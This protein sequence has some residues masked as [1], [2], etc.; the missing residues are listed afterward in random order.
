MFDLGLALGGAVADLG[1]RGD[2]QLGPG[3]GAE[4]LG[5]EILPR[6][7]PQVVVHV[8]RADGLAD[9]HRRR[10]TGTDPRPGAPGSGCTIRA[11]R[12]SLSVTVW[13]LPLL[14][15]NSK[16][17]LDPET[18][19]CRSCS[20]VRPNERLARAYSSLPM[21]IPVQ[22]SRRTTVAST[23]SRGRPWLAQVALHPL[24]RMRGSD[25]AE[26]QHPAELGLVPHLPPLRMVAVLFPAARV[27]AGGLDVAVGRG[28]DP[29]VGVRRWNGER[30]G[31][32]PAR[33]RP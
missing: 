28:T 15:R 21:R 27:A 11:S 6:D 7:L 1:Q 14:P 10:G 2:G 31:S 18:S 5:G 20:V 19:T 30:P 29:D 8:A 33:P 17:M 23:F 4:V 26:G 16:R 32:G 25:L 24:A 13:V 12:R 3:P 22:S 9:V